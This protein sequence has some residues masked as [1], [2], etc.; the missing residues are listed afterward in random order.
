MPVNLDRKNELYL[1]NIQKP[2][3]LDTLSSYM[4]KAI[5]NLTSTNQKELEDN[6]L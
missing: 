3:S 1:Q 6:Y 5:N 2:L 4:D